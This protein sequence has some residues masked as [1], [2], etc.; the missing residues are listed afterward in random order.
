[1]KVRE[2]SKLDGHH[3]LYCQLYK[4]TPE[5]KDMISTGKVRY[6][7]LQIQNSFS[8]FVDNSKKVFNFVIRA[9]A[10][11]NM[12][13][14]KDM[15][16]TFNEL[17]IKNLPN[18]EK[19]EQLE[20]QL[21]EITVSLGEKDRMLAEKDA[22]MKTLSDKL[23]E[24]ATAARDKDLTESVEKLCLSES[25]KTGFKG[26]EKGKVLAFVKTLSD[27]QAKTYFAVHQDILTSVDLG[28]HGE[29]GEGEGATDEAMQ[30]AVDKQAKALSEKTGMT[31]GEAYKEILGTDAKLAEKIL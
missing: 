12:P 4:F 8:K 9:L 20:K 21:G 19:L 5:G 3:S 17:P 11:T 1:M 2:S 15:A 22:E 27:E 24:V 31:L 18:M 6:F 25:N 23:A 26:G 7:S 30:E 14:I 13:V 29:T 28:E 16:P 10:L